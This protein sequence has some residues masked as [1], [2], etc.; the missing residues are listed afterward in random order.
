M[1]VH[2]H[3]FHFLHSFNFW[4]FSISCVSVKSHYFDQIEEKNCP[5]LYCKKSEIT[6][7]LHIP[8]NLLHTP[9]TEL[10]TWQFNLIK[11]AKMI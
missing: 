8:M 6:I 9:H 7:H 4:P 1:P 10:L 11:V 3:L 5:D 2:F